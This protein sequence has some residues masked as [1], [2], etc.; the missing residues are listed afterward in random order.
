MANSSSGETVLQ[1]TMRVLHCF[2]AENAR[3]GA[4]EIARRSGLPSSTAHRLVVELTSV[5]LLERFSDGKYGIGTHAWETFVR[6]NPLER[7]RLQA[8]TILS[9]VREELGQYVCLAVPDFADRTILYVERFD[10][11]DSQLRLLGR[12]AGRLDLHTTSLG[13]VMLAFASPQTIKAVTSSPFKDSISGDI[14][15]GAAVAAM[16]QEI[17]ATGHFVFVGGLIPENTAVA[18]PVFDRKGVVRASVGVVAR[19][20]EIDVNQAVSVVLDACQ[21][22]SVRLQK[23]SLY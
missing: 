5:K 9:D 20:D 10:S 19:N 3:L 21:K 15:D 2:D 22:L 17:R 23:D 8:Q 11:T 1:R 7:M 4:S 14:T 13:L 12:H 18:A 6:A 16:L